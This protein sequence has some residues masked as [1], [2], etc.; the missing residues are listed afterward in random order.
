MYEVKLELVQN[1]NA[2]EGRPSLWVFQGQG[3]VYLVA[4]IAL[5]LSAFKYCNET[6]GLD[7]VPSIIAGLSPLGLVTLFVIYFVNGKPPSY[8]IDYLFWH[9][10]R[11]QDLLWRCG[12]SAAPQFWIKRRA[13]RHPREFG[14]D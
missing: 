14:T 11:L 2:R 5:G 6:L 3:V 7:L 4:G 8:A 13:P 12:I 1:D 10:Y 9:L